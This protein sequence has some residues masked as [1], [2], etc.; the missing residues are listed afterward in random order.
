M[1]IF[2]INEET[3]E[4]PYLKEVVRLQSTVLCVFIPDIR[5]RNVMDR[6]RSKKCKYY[7]NISIS[8]MN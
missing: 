8:Q 1:G 6:G 2:S 7:N 4:C 3:V 5:A